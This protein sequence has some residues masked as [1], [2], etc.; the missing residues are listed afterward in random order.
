LGAAFVQT[1]V[2]IR[3]QVYSN[4]IGLHV[5]AGSTLTVERLHEY[6]GALAARS[7][8]GAQANARATALLGHSVQTQASVLAYADGFNLLG[9]AVVGALLMMLLL[10]NP[11]TRPRAPDHRVAP[12]SS[13]EGR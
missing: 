3:E 10:R 8:G 6:A 5:D 9:F 13:A 11:P 7:V 2:R 4:L 12:S 1:F